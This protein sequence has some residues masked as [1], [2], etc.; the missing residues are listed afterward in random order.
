MGLYHCWG[1][2]AEKQYGQYYINVEVGKAITSA[3]LR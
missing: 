2:E 1:D 3:N